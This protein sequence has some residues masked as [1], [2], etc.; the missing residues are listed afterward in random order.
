MVGEHNDVVS[1]GGVLSQCLQCR[2]DPIQPVKG[3]ERLGSEYAGMVGDLVVV[4]VVDVDALGSL[5]HFLRDHRRVEITLHARWWRREGRRRS[6]HGG[7]AAGCCGGS[8]GRLATAPYQLRNRPHHPPGEPLWIGQEP[9]EGAPCGSG[10][11]SLAEVAHRQDGA[12]RV[13]GEQIAEGK[14]VVGKQ[15]VPFVTRCSMMAA[16]GPRLAIRT[17]LSSRSYH[18]KAGTPATVPC[19]SPADWPAWY[20]ETVVSTLGARTHRTSPIVAE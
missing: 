7:R 3:G 1:P 17:R 15:P 9:G 18:R 13:T 11:A 19:R 8:V 10:V 14:P 2:K 6:I 20:R 4:H 5:T 12:R 16:S